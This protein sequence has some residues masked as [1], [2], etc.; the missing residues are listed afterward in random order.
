MTLTDFVCLVYALWLSCSQ[1]L[2]R[3]FG[4]QI[5]Y[6]SVPD[7]DYYTNASCALNLEFTF[8]IAFFIIAFFALSAST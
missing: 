1:R 7:E 3:L 8:F 2:L 6:L 5:F 4:F